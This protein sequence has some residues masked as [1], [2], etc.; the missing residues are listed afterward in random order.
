MLDFLALLVVEV[1]LK[2]I[3]TGNGLSVVLFSDRIRVFA[4]IYDISRHT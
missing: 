4:N 2:T 3:Q 1:K